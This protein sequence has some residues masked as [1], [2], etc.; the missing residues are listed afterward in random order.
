M[1]TELK[2]ML[3]NLIAIDFHNIYEHQIITLYI[4]NLY[5]IASAAAKSHQSCPT[6]QCYMSVKLGRKE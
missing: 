2:N 6:L 4:L 1:I 3:T 5:N